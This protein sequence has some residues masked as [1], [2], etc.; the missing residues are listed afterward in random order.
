MGVVIGAL[1]LVISMVLCMI[2]GLFFE[3]KIDFALGYMLFFIVVFSLSG[4]YLLIK[5]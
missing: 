1:C 4:I 5:N 3:D 2:F